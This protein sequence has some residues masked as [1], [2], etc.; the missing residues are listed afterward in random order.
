MGSVHW[1]EEEGIIVGGCRLQALAGAAVFTI[2][3][4]LCFSV[5]LAFWLKLDRLRIMASQNWL[6]LHNTHSGATRCV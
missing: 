1:T 5:E 3:V 4:A 2:A 6:A